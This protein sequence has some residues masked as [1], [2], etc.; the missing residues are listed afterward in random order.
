MNTS[1][2]ISNYVSLID[3]IVDKL[4]VAA[5]AAMVEETVTV[6][7]YIYIHMD[8][9]ICLHTLMRQLMQLEYLIY[10]QIINININ[11]YVYQ[12]NHYYYLIKKISEADKCIVY[13]I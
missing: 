10:H 5:Q 1:L 13:M 9:Y 7:T 3:D 6:G 2:I 4:L 12:Y 11:M 8:T